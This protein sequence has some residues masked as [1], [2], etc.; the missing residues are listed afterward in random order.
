MPAFTRGVHVSAPWSSIPGNLD[1]VLATPGLNLIQLDV[2]DEGGEV[3]GIVNGVPALAVRSG[4]LHDYYDLRHITQLAHDRH[5]WVV[6]RI[7]GFKDPIAARANPA[8][9]IRDVHGGI[10]QDGGGV[11]WLNQ[12]SP[13]AWK[14]LINLAKAAARTGVDEVQFDYM[15]F[16]S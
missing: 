7:V 16:P 12:Y 2:K 9:A 11:P 15:R 3:S 13:G 4:A 10:W 8:I 14:Y 1:K 5:I 6:A